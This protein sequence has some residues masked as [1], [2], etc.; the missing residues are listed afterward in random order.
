MVLDEAGLESALDV[1]LPAFERRTGIQVR[2]EKAG[3]ARELD[4]ELSI[5]LYR[6]MQE[7]LNNVVRHSHSKFAAVRLNFQPEAVVL[8]VEDRGIGFQSGDTNGLGLISMRERAELVN[9]RIEFARG[10]DGGAL[11]RVT[12][13]SVCEE[14][15]A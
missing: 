6:V 13:P 14:S 7:G 15:H 9:G 3:V 11:V 5:Q 2:Y 4:R 8:E 1:Y 10:G 12:V